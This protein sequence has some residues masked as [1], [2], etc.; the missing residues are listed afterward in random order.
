MHFNSVSFIFVQ[1]KCVAILNE[2]LVKGCNWYLLFMLTMQL[3]K[4]I[5]NIAVVHLKFKFSWSKE[6]IVTKQKNEKIKIPQQ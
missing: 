4:L 6:Q 3:S 1:I 5:S 2:Y